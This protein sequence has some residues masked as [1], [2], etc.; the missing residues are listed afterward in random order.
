MKRNVDYLVIHCTA[1]VQTAKVESIQRYWR[2]TLKWKSPGYHKLITPTG[3]AV[4][5]ADDEHVCNGVRGYNSKSIHISYIGGI[6][7]KGKPLDNRTD[8]Q[9]IA[10]EWEV[11]QY[12]KKYPGIKVVGHRDFPGVNKAC[13]SFDVASWLK[14]SFL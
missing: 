14:E 9:K 8:L 5:L 7:A 13:P 3:E 6:D 11:K 10:L 1:T 12:K 2:E 4:R